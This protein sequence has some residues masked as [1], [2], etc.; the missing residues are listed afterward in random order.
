[1][2][3][4]LYVIGAVLAALALFLVW[5]AAY[6]V[7]VAWYSHSWALWARFAKGRELL[8]PIQSA[9]HEWENPAVKKLVARATLGSPALILKLLEHCPGHDVGRQGQAVPQ[10]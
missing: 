9:L 4:A 7:A 3:T 6:C 5:E 1:M 10:F 2:R 8:L